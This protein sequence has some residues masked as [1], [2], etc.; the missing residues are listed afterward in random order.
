MAGATDPLAGLRVRT[1]ILHRQLESTAAFSRLTQEDV[2]LA[3]V[4]RALILFHAFYD[5]LEQAL[6]PRLE[7]SP[8]AGLYRQRRALLASDLAALGVQPSVTTA[9][10]LPATDAGL[11]GVI[12]AVEGSALGGQV[13][14][15]HFAARLGREFDYF[16]ALAEGVGG[17]WQRVLA[18]LRQVLVDE[19][20]LD[21][22]SA[23]AALVF[24]SLIRLADQ[25]QPDGFC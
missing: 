7:N 17:H 15:R 3:D 21:E 20:R 4:V 2:G 18:V 24:S 16:T 8:H 5:A 19:D 9:V 23:G 14:A 12:Y 6:L 11:L 22:V 25:E 1:A 13:L 10:D